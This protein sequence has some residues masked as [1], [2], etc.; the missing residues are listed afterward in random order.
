MRDWWRTARIQKGER[1]HGWVVQTEA[2]RGEETRKAREHVYLICRPGEGIRHSVKRNG[3]GNVVLAVSARSRGQDGGDNIWA[4]EWE[5]HRRCGDV[6]AIQCKHRPETRECSQRSA[7]H[8]GAPHG[9]SWDQFVQ[10]VSIPR[11]I[12]I[13]CATFIPNRS[14]RFTTFPGLLN[15]WPPNPPP[16]PMP[17]WG[18]V[19][20]IVFSRLPDES[21]DVYQIW[22]QSVQPFDNFQRL[23]NVWPHNPPPGMPLVYVGARLFTH[24]T[25]KY[26]LMRLLM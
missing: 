11:F 14:S 9:V 21:A 8:C 23:L 24:F 19:V 3:D 10:H 26:P 16:P 2:V 25:T 17:A 1:N 4:D 18:I 5:S 6:W 7:V 13:I 12:C 20:R 22:C 15:S